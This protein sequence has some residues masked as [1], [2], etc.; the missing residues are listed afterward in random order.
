MDNKQ[1]GI[2]SKGKL[3][4]RNFLVAI[5]RNFGHIALSKQGNILA[6][7]TEVYLAQVNGKSLSSYL[8]VWLDP[9]AQVIP[10]SCLYLLDLPSSRWLH[11]QAGSLLVVAKTSISLSRLTSC[12]LKTP[13]ERHLTSTHKS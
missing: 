9:D 12:P 1:E 13:V 4:L 8:Q 7:I 2:I 3:F 10:E 6:C 11:F 5:D